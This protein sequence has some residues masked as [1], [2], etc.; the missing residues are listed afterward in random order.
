MPG[1][2]IHTSIT[3]AFSPPAPQVPGVTPGSPLY[4]WCFGHP[5][6][7]GEM[8][9][10]LCCMHLVNAWVLL[11]IS[12]YFGNRFCIY[13]VDFVAVS[14]VFCI[15]MIVGLVVLSVIKLCMFGKAVFKY[16]AF[17]MMMCVLRLV[18]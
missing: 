15:V 2:L 13:F 12:L 5:I 17:H 8:R 7:Y 3:W 14:L 10:I 4:P 6:P 16:E 11:K 9:D 18:V 1:A